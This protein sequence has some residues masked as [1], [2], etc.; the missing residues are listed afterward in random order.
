VKLAIRGLTVAFGGR[1]V[2]DVE[3]LDLAQGEILGVAGESGSGK[4]SMAAAVLGLTVHQGGVAAGSIALDGQELVGL[5]EGALREI[6]GSRIAM[7]FQNPAA[8]FNPTFRIGD[9]F[10][11][12]LRLHGATR[13]EARARAERAMEEVLLT[14]ALLERYPHEISGGQ[15]QRTA[16][17]LAVALE[18]EVLVADEPTSALD[19]TVQSEIINILRR[20]REQQ[21]LSVLIISHDLAVLGELCDRIAVMHDG[22]VVEQGASG[23]VL[24][25]PAHEYTREL[26]A[27]IPT[28]GAHAAL[29]NDD[30]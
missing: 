25:Q 28:L 1:C 10:L 27:S 29:V 8:T 7:I 23:Q 19:V 15:A 14:P 6:R 5:D 26:I 18:A 11:R 24:H 16:I 22:K 3:Q 13:E 9:V 12:A 21:D 30:A 2:V 4:S 20:V 17:A